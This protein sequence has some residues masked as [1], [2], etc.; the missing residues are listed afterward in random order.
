MK[1]DAEWGRK[2]EKDSSSS[3]SFLFFLGVFSKKEIHS[4]LCIKIVANLL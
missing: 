2:G 1:N 3:S 4:V